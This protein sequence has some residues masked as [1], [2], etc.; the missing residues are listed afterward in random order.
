MAILTRLEP[1]RFRSRRWVVELDGEIWRHAPKA[2]VSKLGLEIGDDIDPE[3]LTAQLSRLEPAAARERALYLISG[4]ERP[5]EDIR[6]KLADDGYTSDVAEQIV[7]N[8]VDLG[9]I[10]DERYAEILV[11]T[12]AGGR[13]YGRS[14]V[15]RE[16]SRRGV[17]EDV[18]AE[19]LEVA[20]AVGVEPGRAL[21]Q[22]RRILRSHRTLD[23]SRL[24][25]RLARRGFAPGVALS[26]A[27]DAIGSDDDD[28]YV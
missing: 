21:E 3:L 27:R 24:A 1:E 16:L 18:A 19:A 17:G 22:A 28:L 9:L 12:L 23:V 5:A 26:A 8:F 2:V 25:A 6:R 10:D 7:A 13:G 14:R 4:Q 11:R 20:C 15:A